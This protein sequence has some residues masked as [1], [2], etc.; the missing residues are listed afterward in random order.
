MRQVRTTASSCT[1]P[2]G[3]DA[4]LRGTA[5]AA[6]PT[7]RDVGS[8][9]APCYNDA[10]CRAAESAPAAAGGVACAWEIAFAR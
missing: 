2:R 7:V 5:G 6:E 1:T 10:A 8:T 3:A 9:P 4:C